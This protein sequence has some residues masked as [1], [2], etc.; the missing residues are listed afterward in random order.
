MLMS[1]LRFVLDLLETKG[2]V[3]YKGIPHASLPEVI[4]AGKTLSLEPDT[5][6]HLLPA[7]AHDTIVD[8]VHAAVTAA[9]QSNTFP[10]YDDQVNK[11]RVDGIY[12]SDGKFAFVSKP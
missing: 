2:W 4:S 11:G 8:E 3:L 5:Y 1:D 6:Y 10:M 12:I 7:T 9:A